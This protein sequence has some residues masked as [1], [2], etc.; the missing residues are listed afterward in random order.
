MSLPLPETLVGV[1]AMHFASF[2]LGDDPRVPIH[3]YSDLLHL[4]YSWGATQTSSIEA[5]IVSQHER[6]NSGGGYDVASISTSSA[7]TLAF[8]ATLMSITSATSNS[9]LVT[10]NAG[11]AHGLSTVWS[12]YPAE[13]R[14]LTAIRNSRLN[15]ADLLLTPASAAVVNDTTF[16]VNQAY[17]AASHSSNH[18]DGAGSWANFSSGTTYSFVHAPELTTNEYADV[19]SRAW[20]ANGLPFH[21]TVSSL[22]GHVELSCPEGEYVTSSFGSRVKRSLRLVTTEGDV[23]HRL[24][25]DVGT[26]QYTF[27]H[28]KVY[29]LVP[30]DVRSF[31]LP[32][33]SVTSIV[34][35]LYRATNHAYLDSGDVR[36]LIVNE[37]NGS[38]TSVTLSPGYYDPTVLAGHTT[39]LLSS[40]SGT[41]S[42]MSVTYNSL[43]GA[44]QFRNVAG[45]S[46]GLDFSERP[47]LA[48]VFGFEAVALSGSATYAS[49][50]RA[51]SGALVHDPQPHF[52]ADWSL[53][54][55]TSQLMMHPRQAVSTMFATSL[56]AATW[57][58]TLPDDTTPAVHG[59]QAFDVVRVASASNLYSVVVQQG[60]VAASPWSLVTYPRL[61]DIGAAGADVDTDS[62]SNLLVTQLRRN[63]WTWFTPSFEP[64]RTSAYN[65]TVPSQWNE[66]HGISRVI[67]GPQF[68]TQM[69]TNSLPRPIRLTPDNVVFVELVDPTHIV[70]EH[71]LIRRGRLGGK[72]AVWSQ[73]VLTPGYAQVHSRNNTVV[74]HDSVNVHHVKLRFWNADFIPVDWRGVEYVLSVVFQFGVRN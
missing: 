58:T 37:P 20:S 36:S 68:V 65:L 19:V 21:V 63:A 59:L 31:R 26:R 38:L 5:R 44:Y 73:L 16:T 48:S 7:Y 8:P 69:A 67:G 2:C 29:E 60:G 17:L 3:T 66:F 12:Y 47:L 46:F 61:A 70:S 41:T 25:A 40:M 13:V 71:A 28:G 18:A 64:M 53:N 1:E 4:G 6:T 43:S 42:Q 11:G 49:T 74:F 24:G 10:L 33:G 45:A 32:Q 23:M 39:V 14:S 57:T 54:S 51:H 34:D 35:T 27:E 55:A 72:R 50:K 52:R 15:N 30:L 62:V 22:T 9:S 56:T